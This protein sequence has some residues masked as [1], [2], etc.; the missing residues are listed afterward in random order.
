LPDVGL[1]E[2]EDA[3]T[4]ERVLVDTHRRRIRDAFAQSGR[5]EQ[6]S[7]ASKLKSMGTDA[8]ELS[9]DRPYMK[10][11]MSFFHRRERRLKH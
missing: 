2:L 6:A 11:L 5:D 7:L 1:I 8:L 4:G 10:D 9:T 3:E